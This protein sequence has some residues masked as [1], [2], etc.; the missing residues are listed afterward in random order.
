MIMDFSKRKPLLFAVAAGLIAALAYF[1]SGVFPAYEYRTDVFI[2][3]Y[4]TDDSFHSFEPVA[5]TELF[6]RDT[7][8]LQ[9]TTEELR[10]LGVAE[11]RSSAIITIVEAGQTIR[12]HS[13]SVES[14]ID[15]VM[16]VHRFVSDGILARLRPRAAY[17]RARLN[18]R[19][20]SAEERLKSASGNLAIFS[21]IATD[22]RASQAKTLELAR[23]LTYQIPELDQSEKD[24]NPPART[25]VGAE[26]GNAADLSI[27]GQLAM[28]QKL[29]LAE[30]PFLR[31]DSARTVVSLGQT[32]AQSL[33]TINDLSQQ[34][35]AF[36]EPT[37]TEFVA[38]SV[39]PTKPRVLVLLMVG[40]VA[41]F[42]TY[43]VAARAIPKGKFR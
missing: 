33:Q 42:A 1:V 39:S 38:R 28:Y 19:L 3:E 8:F 6:V 26:T 5:A 25:G 40:L 29:G 2:G 10:R 23:K 31:A 41:G 32:A 36:R 13:V 15:R 21:E 20:S 17:V 27:R 43:Y 30:I 35:T 22:A 11:L 16:A 7:L 4:A 37:V 12:I 18:N 24:S 9:P 14:D 34:I